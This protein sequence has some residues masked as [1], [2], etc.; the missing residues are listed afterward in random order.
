MTESIN[1]NNNDRLIVFDNNMFNYELNF[2]KMFNNKIIGRYIFEKI[3]IELFPCLYVLE[4]F[5]Q[6]ANTKMYIGHYF[7][8]YVFDSFEELNN[9]NIF[10]RI[11]T[12]RNIEIIIT[13][14]SKTLF[15][16]GNYYYK[17]EFISTINNEII[18]EMFI[19]FTLL[20]YIK[21]N[22]NIEY[23]YLNYRIFHLNNK[24]LINLDI[25]S[26]NTFAN[27][28]SKIDLSNDIYELE[29]DYLIIQNNETKKQLIQLLKK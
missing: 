25:E 27:I 22:K 9:N 11:K 6:Q 21:K 26:L 23:E 19:P 1:N 17:C 16:F 24:T 4:L 10:Y 28:I 15:G 5:L 3:K 2:Q 18:F 14:Y 8:D 20:S 13:L 29:F 12:N 7:L